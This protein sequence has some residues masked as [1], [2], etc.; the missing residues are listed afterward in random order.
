MSKNI[1]TQRNYRWALVSYASPNEFQRV[2]LKALHYAYI[3]HNLEDCTP[4]Y[5]VL[6]V[7]RSQRTLSAIRKDIASEQNTNGQKL[8]DLCASFRYL[9]HEESTDK[10]LYPQSSVVCDDLTFWTTLKEDDGEDYEVDHLIDDIISGLSLRALARKYGRDFMKNREKYEQFAYDVS[11]HERSA[12]PFGPVSSELD[13][14]P[15]QSSMF[16]GLD[17]GTSLKYD[18]RKKY[19]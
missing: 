14:T 5:H 3:Y 18:H 16:E 11:L 10:Q 1:L 6:L 7:F 12:T 4:H 17:D 9:T 8:R 19:E 2:C 15:R 13:V